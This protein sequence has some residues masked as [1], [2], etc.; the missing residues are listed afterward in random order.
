MDR[1]GAEY[2][3]KDLIRPKEELWHKNQENFLDCI[4]KSKDI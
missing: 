2:K 4:K 1:V 3:T